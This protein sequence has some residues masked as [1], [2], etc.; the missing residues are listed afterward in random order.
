MNITKNELISLI[1]KIR[2]DIGHK[3]V[4]VEISH[5]IFDNN[6]GNLLIITPD[7]P[8]KSVIIGKGGWV[9]GRL[10]EE[11]GINSIHVEANSDFIVPVYRMK[12]ALAKLEKIISDYSHAE[13]E[14]LINLSKLLNFRIKN[15]YNIELLIEKLQKIHT[16][17][18]KIRV[19]E[20]N[21]EKI[22][23]TI[24]EVQKERY[25]EIYANDNK[26]DFSAVVALSG[27]VDSGASLLIAKM[28]G[29]NPL[30]VT[31]DPGKIILP[32]HFRNSAENLTRK[33]GV[34]HHYLD[35]DMQEIIDGSLEGRFHPCGMCSKTIERTI[36]TYTQENN[37]PFL[38]YGDLLSTGA[39]SFQKEG[40]V[41]R[42]NLPAVLSL[43]KGEV[44]NI[45]LKWGMKKRTIYGCPLIGQV[46]KNQPHMRRFSIQR[47]LR[48][49]RAGVLEP[50]EALA[51]IKGI[52]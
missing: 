28:L 9:V 32:P 14:P 23:M 17:S 24:K 16:K 37:I 18:N 38:I 41:L 12:L 44:K 30:A 51:Q 22:G 26:L 36:L 3:D 2:R 25:N 27:G 11:L 46:H 4:E 1:S 6:K 21:S 50:G 49:T 10:R 35:V 13:K 39:N 40:D 7:R 19:D 29:F 20:N 5:L 52:L 31:V 15:P 48:E 47:V 33:L 45:A 34:K 42:I 43:K 8:E